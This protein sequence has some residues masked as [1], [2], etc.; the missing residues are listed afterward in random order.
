MPKNIVWSKLA[1][2][3]FEHILEYLEG[4]W[5]NQ[6]VNQFIDITFRIL[7]QIAINSKQFP[8]IYKKEKIR[9]CVINRQNTLYYKEGK[10]EVE[11]LRI[12][13]TRQD[14]KKLKFK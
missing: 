8:V 13:D 3:D 1:D 5:G 11:I 14:P 12:F 2:K 7:S 9:K 6:V 10:N 4:E